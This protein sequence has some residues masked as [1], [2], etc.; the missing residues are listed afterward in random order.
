MS[1]YRV[2]KSLT[3]ASVPI[4][5]SLPFLVWHAEG[6]V[7]SL[8]FSVTRNPID[9]FSVTSLD[10][11]MGWLGLPARLPMLVMLLA[12]Y[13]LAWRRKVGMYVASLFAMS[14]FVNFN[15]VLFRQ[16]L[17]WIVPLI[18]LV[19]L[20]LWEGADPP[21]DPQTPSPGQSPSQSGSP[22]KS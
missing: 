4:L 10:G 13:A 15:S 17:A 22:T 8:A 2:R 5:T 11:Q 12:V 19:M 18:P 3:I 9:H 1:V 6:F 20:D 7:K 16:Y 21:T 14:T